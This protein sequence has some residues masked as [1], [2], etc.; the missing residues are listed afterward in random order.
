MREHHSVRA[1]LLAECAY[2]L[3]S[4]C[5]GSDVSAVVDELPIH[6]GMR[7]YVCTASKTNPAIGDQGFYMQAPSAAFAMIDVLVAAQASLAPVSLARSVVSL[8]CKTLYVRAQ[9]A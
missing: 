7:S 3:L 6:K 8:R 5:H 4:Y 1:K 2:G 9:D